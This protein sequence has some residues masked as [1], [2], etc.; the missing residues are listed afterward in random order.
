ML[1][2]QLHKMG[3]NF[4][5]LA[6]NV[7]ST[8]PHPATVA[9]YV[10]PQTSWSRGG[11]GPDTSDWG[12]KQPVLSALAAYTE[13][14]HKWGTTGHLLPRFRLDVWPGICVRELMK[15]CLSLSL[16]LSLTDDTPLSSPSSLRHGSRRMLLGG[17]QPATSLA[18]ASSTSG[19]GFLG[20]TL[21][22][23]RSDRPFLATAS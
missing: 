20:P 14:Y 3:P 22:Q 1:I 18:A 21:T 6:D 16:S 2:S 19:R 13:R 11:H 10:Y 9:T 12:R 23:T 17:F 5:A 15:V 4:A 7:P 8:F